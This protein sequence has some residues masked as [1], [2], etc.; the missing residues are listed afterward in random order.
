MVSQFWDQHHFYVNSKDHTIHS[1]DLRFQNPQ[2]P[3]NTVN[4]LF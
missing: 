2:K 3:E 4:F 1:K